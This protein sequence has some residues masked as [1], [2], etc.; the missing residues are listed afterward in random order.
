[1]DAQFSDPIF[2]DDNAAREA[3]EAVRWPD[4]PVCV[5]T[6]ARQ[7]NTMASPR[8]RARSKRIAPACTTAMTVKARLRSLWAPFSSICKRVPLKNGGLLRT[9]CVRSCQGDVSPPR[10]PPHAQA[11]RFK[12]AWFMMHRLRFAMAPAGAAPLGGPGKS[13]EADETFLG[14]SPKTRKAAPLHAKPDRVVLVLW[15]EAETFAR[16]TLTVSGTQFLMPK[17]IHDDSRLL[18]DGAQHEHRR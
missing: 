10:H 16:F 7:G 1:M 8:S 5:F 12:T 11:S 6:A 2:T 4:G 9:F 15:N 13:V 18:T 14:K 3:L 17:V